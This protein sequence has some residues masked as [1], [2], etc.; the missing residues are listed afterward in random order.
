MQEYTEAVKEKSTFK[1]TCT[2][3]NTAGT[4]VTPD[5]AIWTLT[6]EDGTVIN[7]REDVSIATPST[8]NDIILSGD[9]L[10][11]SGNGKRVVTTEAV[12]DSDEG[13]NLTLKDEYIF[14]IEDLLNV[15]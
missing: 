1:I 10:A 3:K 9:D 2:W 11:F 14:Y 15:T 6:D 4:A 7:S 8:T 12:Y 13:N 5:S